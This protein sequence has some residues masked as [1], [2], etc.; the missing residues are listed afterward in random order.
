MKLI[1]PTPVVHLATLVVGVH[2]NTGFF[3]NKASFLVIYLLVIII[4]V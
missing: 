1:P 4:L 2:Y 3:V